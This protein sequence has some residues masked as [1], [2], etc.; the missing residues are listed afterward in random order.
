V[1]PHQQSASGTG[2]VSVDMQKIWALSGKEGFV[3]GM[4][5][6]K[7]SSSTRGVSLTTQVI[8]ASSD[9]EGFDQCMQVIMALIHSFV[10]VIFDRKWLLHFK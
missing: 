2:S 6:I 3:Q 9:T 8:K 10:F 5:V 1:F 4:N 7:T